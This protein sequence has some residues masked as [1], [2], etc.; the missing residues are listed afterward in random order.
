[1]TKA[2]YYCIECRK[3]LGLLTKHCRR[4]SGR[5]HTLIR[6]RYCEGCDHVSSSTHLNPHISSAQCSARPFTELQNS[7]MGI[8][9]LQTTAKEIIERDGH[10]L[11]S[12]LC[13]SVQ[14]SSFSGKLFSEP[15][16]STGKE[17]SSSSI[18]FVSII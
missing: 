1:M 18:N 15:Q 12:S 3:C 14:I 13:R 8:E 6:L 17:I 5:G 10:P 9:W 7:P 16:T 11:L 2:C 4:P